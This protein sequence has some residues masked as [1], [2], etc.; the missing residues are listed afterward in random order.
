M[1]TAILSALTAWAVVLLIEKAIDM[2]PTMPA[3]VTV[4][5]TVGVAH[6]T[7]GFPGMWAPIIVAVCAYALTVAIDLGLFALEERGGMKALLPTPD[8]DLEEMVVRP[9]RGEAA[10]LDDDA[11]ERVQPWAWLAAAA[12]GELRTALRNEGVSEDA[13]RL[14]SQ[15]LVGS[16]DADEAAASCR[17]QSEALTGSAKQVLEQ[18]Q[19]FEQQL[20]Q[21]ME[22]SAQLQGEM[23]ALMSPAQAEAGRDMVPTE[24]SAQLLGAH[25]A[26]HGTSPI[27]TALAINAVC[28][29][30]DEEA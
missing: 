29:D 19:Q 24:A 16:Y 10:Y 17:E 27:L 30:E 13:L 6:L 8:H 18:Q 28:R 23:F 22:Q 15:T 4:G 5:A 9:K 26:K 7:M 14:T 3:G 21:L 25:A 20:Q 1:M 11:L 2:T 12:T